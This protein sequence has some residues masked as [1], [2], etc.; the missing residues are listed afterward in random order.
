MSFDMENLE[1]LKH[2]LEV[3]A[4]DAG[5]SV[6]YDDD[7]NQ[8]KVP[9]DIDIAFY[10]PYHM[11]PSFLDEKYVYPTGQDKRR[12]RRKKERAKNKRK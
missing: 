1:R 9:D 2:K 5:F 10:Q 12:E 6:V 8:P 3:L 7:A 4:E 11:L